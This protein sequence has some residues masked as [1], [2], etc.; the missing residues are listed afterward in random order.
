MTYL[1]S[2]N[3]LIR[4]TKIPTYLKRLYLNLHFL[5]F[6]ICLLVGISSSLNGETSV[7][8]LSDPP[9]NKSRNKN[10]ICNK[11]PLKSGAFVKL[12][13]GS[14]K[15]QG[16]LLETLI[17][18]QNGLVGRLPEVSAWLQKDG[19]AW[20]AGDGRGKWGWEE[21]PY[22]LRG[23][24][25]LAQ[26]LEDKP[27][28][29]ET[30]EWISAVL[31]SQRHNGHFGPLRVFGDD[32]SP[33]L[34]ANMI[35]L[36]CLQSYYEYSEDARV[37]DLMRNYFRYQMEIPDDKMFTHFWQYYRGGDNLESV[38]WLYNLTGEPWLLQLAEKVHRNTANWT[39]EG[40]LPSWHG[41]NVSQAF[42]EP[43]IYYLQSG[44]VSDL[45]ATYENI[46]L[47]QK[48]FG[49]FP[50]GMFAADENARE[51]YTDPRQGIE[52]CAVVEQIRSNLRLLSI[53][54]DTAW[55]DH[56]EDIIFNTF[57]AC[58]AEDHRSLRYLTSSNLISSDSRDY[59][60]GIENIGPMF[61]FNPLSHRCCQHNHSQ[62][63]PRYIEHLW[64]A[65]HDNGLCSTCYGPS[66]VNAIVSDG[67]KVRLEEITR[68]PFEE[69]I[70]LKIT[71]END[72]EFPL[73]LRI[74]A[75]CDKS[76]ITVNGTFVAENVAPSTYVK[77]NRR[78]KSNDIVEVSLPMDVEI[79]RWRKS[80][81]SVSVS[82]GPLSYSLLIDSEKIPVDSIKTSAIDSQWRSD[83]NLES[84]PSFEL[85]STSP[86]NYGLLLDKEPV[87]NNFKVVSHGWPNSNYPFAVKESPISIQ[88]KGRKI[89][90]WTQDLTGLCGRLQESPVYSSMP[91]ELIS[92]VPMGAAHLRISMFPEIVD[93]PD[94]PTWQA[95][96][97]AILK[98]K[99][100]T[101]HCSENDSVQA[102]ADGLLPCASNDQAIPRLT[103]LPNTG[104]KEWIQA[105]FNEER[106]V[107]SISIYWSDDSSRY[108]HA[109]TG[110]FTS[111]IS[112]TSCQ[113]P[114]S[115]RLLH[116]YRGEWKE[117]VVSKPEEVCANRFNSI[118]FPSLRTKSL[119][120][121]VELKKNA[122]AGVLEWVINDE[123]NE[124]S[125]DRKQASSMK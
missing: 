80:K 25:L 77:I 85:R 113:L 31:V 95:A 62:G 115:W 10:Y 117:I 43:A 30:E 56:V 67:V 59:S 101:S 84:W 58:L 68:Y 65:T 118:N 42:G 94:L 110:P 92:L 71:P 120:L 99:P 2:V 75:W 29:K 70:S 3:A 88:C 123:S 24:V 89:P 38:Y 97:N 12:P 26:L 100:T 23:A 105:D 74:P 116:K 54:G 121:E 106:V 73:Y 79:R 5:T 52:T 15:P 124:T 44:N 114:Q 78:W 22:W 82:R 20:L 69:K 32:D 8:V 19:N 76:S 14:I 109:P 40:N 46:Q 107:N 57:P 122:S 112:N 9:A 102:I 86:W 64:M 47:I 91:N 55:A 83:I 49:Q 1:R 11:P 16:W 50:G 48:R 7:V 13:I 28:I 33:D 119:R 66:I 60:P 53:T 61:T 90:E 21:V 104:T 4:N 41:V 81:N 125:Q 6:F 34:W 18:Q 39:M 37:L 36:T 98:Y 45:K 103:F 96:E 87:E 63:W 27:L 111:S 108:V 35:M 72:V 17:R 93:D 51:G